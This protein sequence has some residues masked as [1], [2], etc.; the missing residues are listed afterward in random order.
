MG[1]LRCGGRAARVPCGREPVWNEW[2]HAALH[3]LP[4]RALLDGA[5]ASGEAGR[6]E[7]ERG[8]CVHVPEHRADVNA[9]E[10]RGATPLFI[11]S[12]G[13]HLEVVRL[14]VE[15]RADVL[16]AAQGGV[17]ALFM[18]AQRGHFEVVRVLADAGASSEIER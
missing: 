16:T 9:A 7:R 4:Q 1:A 2:C 6:C 17:T 18:A 15:Q 8:G 14:L 3:R 5:L 11:A 13:G 12:C 10:K